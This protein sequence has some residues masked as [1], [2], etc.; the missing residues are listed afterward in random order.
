MESGF[1]LDFAAAETCL[2]SFAAYVAAYSSLLTATPRAL[3]STEALSKDV[4]A[5]AAD[6]RSHDPIFQQL[7]DVS[8]TREVLL[9]AHVARIL[10]VDTCLVCWLGGE[11]AIHLHPGFS[12]F[13]L[14]LFLWLLFLL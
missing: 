13:F 1:Q 14:L 10:E 7:L 9:C 8:L 6:E 2:A 4:A 11:E 5:C 12:V 3:A